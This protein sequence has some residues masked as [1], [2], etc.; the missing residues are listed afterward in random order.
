MYNHTAEA[1]QFDRWQQVY[2][3]RLKCFCTPDDRG[4]ARQVMEWGETWLDSFQGRLRSGIIDSIHIFIAPDRAT[5]SKLTGNSAPLWSAAV[6]I[7]DHGAVIVFNAD[8][9]TSPGRARRIL[10]HELGHLILYR[11]GGR[12]HLP[13]WFDEGVAQLWSAEWRIEETVQLARANRKNQLPAL[14]DLEG[15][16]QLPAHQARIAY[17]ASYDAVRFLLVHI[18]PSVI[19]EILDNLNRGQ[20]FS[21]AFY[22]AC[23]QSTEEF[24]ASWRQNLNDHYRWAIFLEWPI[25]FALALMLFFILAIRSVYKRRRLQ[26]ELWSLN[27]EQEKMEEN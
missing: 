9:A 21:G 25:I 1:T 3:R 14:D 16:L 8:P 19:D 18:G 22:A 15:L 23:N 6:A 27:D 26:I 12:K 11:W 17:A 7:P 20:S 4:Y 5:F 2:S 10:I 24:E 13:R